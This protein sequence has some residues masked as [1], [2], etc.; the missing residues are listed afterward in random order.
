MMNKGGRIRNVFQSGQ[1]DNINGKVR[2]QKSILS[3]GLK[4]ISEEIPYLNSF[5][6]GIFINSGSRD[7]FSGKPGIAH[8]I[9]HLLFRVTPH[10]TSRQIS[11]KFEEIGAYTNAYTAKEFTNYHL[12]ALSPNFKKSFRLLSDLVL[13]DTFRKKEFEAE[14]K[15]ILEEI[16]LYNDDPDEL[17]FDLGEEMIFGNVPMGMPIAGTL[18]SINSMTVHD[19]SDFYSLHY[20]PT[21]TI[22]A[23]TG[24]IN[25]EQLVAEAESRFGSI[26]LPVK[27][28][29]RQGFSE[30]PIRRITVNKPVQQSYYLLG[31]RLPGANSQDKYPV[32]LMNIM[33][34]EGM[35]S[36]LQN[37]VRDKLGLAYSIDSETY[38]YSDAGTF[39]ISSVVDS[40]NIQ[41]LNEVIFREMD[42]AVNK[43]FFMSELNRAKE[44]LKANII[45]ENESL[46]TR[47]RSLYRNEIFGEADIEETIEIIDSTNLNKV[48]ELTSKYLDH[49]YWSSITINPDEE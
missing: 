34:C 47:M 25:H 11:A 31:R 23:V 18:D 2:F 15:V 13:S 44:Q 27:E 30:L 45:M 16:K 48:N 12:R 28:I 46:S 17:I 24:N 1:S 38:F 29:P 41:Q 43:G 3:N 37:V 22:I 8:F 9:E 40:E 4:I 19:L 26:V 14:K 49:Q 5:S 39:Y 7:D 35:S 6:L 36:R 21:N 10:G 33:L 32:I 20:Q 42:K